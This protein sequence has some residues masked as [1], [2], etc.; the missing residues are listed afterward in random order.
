MATVLIVFFLILLIENPVNASKLKDLNMNDYPL[1]K[2]LG[3]SLDS[4]LGKKLEDAMFSQGYMEQYQ[5]VMRA[6]R[7]SFESFERDKERRRRRGKSS[8][9]IDREGIVERRRGA[10]RLR[11]EV[12]RRRARSQALRRDKL[13]TQSLRSHL[14]HSKQST[15]RDSNAVPT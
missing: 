4:K 3:F 13:N 12:G 5:D 7:E 14:E 11:S 10:G 6:S 8:T 15:Q 1:T 2:S 9:E